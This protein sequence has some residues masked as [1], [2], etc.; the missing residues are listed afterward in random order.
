V[1]KKRYP[2][3]T[4]AYKALREGG[5]MPTVLNAANEIAVA[6]FLQGRIGF[7]QIHRVI[8]RTMQNHRRRHAVAIDEILDVDRWAREKANSFVQ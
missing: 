8:D 4:L 1:E 2:A 6:A 7:R 3:L 5:T